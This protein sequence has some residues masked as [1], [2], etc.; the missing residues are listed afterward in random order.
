LKRLAVLV[1]GRGTNL[2]ALDRA[3]RDGSLPASLALVGADREAPALRWAEAQGITTFFADARRLGM[4]AWEQELLAAL[5]DAAVDAVVLAGFLRILSPSFVERFAGRIVNVHP[6]LLPA[7]PGLDGIGQAMRYGAK[8]T[9]VTVHFVDQGLDAGPIILQ[10]ALPVLGGETRVHA[11]EHRL[12]PEALRLLVLGRLELEGR[13][14][15]IAE[16]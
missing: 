7:F 15:H 12:L 4:P 13:I 5:E 2:M 9:G 1:S 6:S 14:V 11:I 8:V 10:E 16:G 3:M